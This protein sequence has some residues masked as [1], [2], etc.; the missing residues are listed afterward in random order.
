MEVNMY[1]TKENVN[2]ILD[3][4]DLK[5]FN[6]YVDMKFFLKDICNPY[7]TSN[8]RYM[9]SLELHKYFI[10]L[11]SILTHTF[12]N[13]VYFVFST[14]KIKVEGIPEYKSVYYSK[15]FDDEE[16]NQI[17]ENI[18]NVYDTLIYSSITSGDEKFINS[19]HTSLSNKDE[20]GFIKT[21]HGDRIAL[22]IT[23]DKIFNGYD[24]MIMIDPYDLSNGEIR[25]Y[26]TSE[27]YKIVLAIAGYEEYSISGIPGIKEK[28]VE[29]ILKKIID[30]GEYIYYNRTSRNQP[31]FP[32]SYESLSKVSDISIE[33]YQKILT[34]WKFLN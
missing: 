12:K 23:R 29:K 32:I 10:D 21:H 27:Y 22:V 25:D 20:F 9:D 19:S 4:L 34:N 24:D 13:P 17:L 2:K 16:R 1:I 7:R 11:H 3:K 28:T 5:E 18:K 8:L 33:E 31:L 6:V 30:S 15:Y 26:N 14:E